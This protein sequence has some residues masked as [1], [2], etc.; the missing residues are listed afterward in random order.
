MFPKENKN[1]SEQ[2]IESRIIKTELVNWRELKFIQQDDFKEWL[3][4]GNKKL[5]IMSATV[6][7]IKSLFPNT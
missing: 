7:S 6:N 5:E 2:I 4:N 1:M 3:P